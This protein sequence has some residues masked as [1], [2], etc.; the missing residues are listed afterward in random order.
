MK[1]K[2]RSCYELTFLMEGYDLPLADWE[3]VFE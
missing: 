3:L 2:K 1:R